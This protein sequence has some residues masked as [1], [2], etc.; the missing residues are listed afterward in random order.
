MPKI[1]NMNEIEAFL[2]QQKFNCVFPQYKIVEMLG[3]GNFGTAFLTESNNVIKFTLDQG[4]VSTCKALSGRRNLNL[5]NIMA[6]NKSNF[7][8]YNRSYTWILQERLFLNP[9]L[10]SKIKT[11]LYDFKHT[12]FW[13]YAGPM[14]RLSNDDLQVIYRRN[15]NIEIDKARNLLIEYI[16]HL[17]ENEDCNRY[18]TNS[19]IQTRKDSSLEFF[20]FINDAYHEL[21]SICP[22]GRIDFNEGNFLFDI[23]GKMKVIDFQ[24]T[25][26]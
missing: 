13:L 1:Y 12:W 17:N 11:S 25:D 10:Q 15:N 19:E 21:V 7:K 9:N 14:N 4:E 5:C 6:V 22:S 3:H 16:D 8:F 23:N 26:I 18:L 24:S 20:D 2:L